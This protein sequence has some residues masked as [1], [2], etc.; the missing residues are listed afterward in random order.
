[1]SLSK[2]LAA[3][4]TT[5]LLATIGLQSTASAGPA[6]TCKGAITGGTYES[7]VVPEG[8]KCTLT[9]VTVA[10]QVQARKDSKLYVRTSNIKLVHGLKAEIVHVFNSTIG[11]HIHV[12]QGNINDKGPDIQI[13]DTKVGGNI[14]LHDNV[15]TIE[16]QRNV[17]SGQIQIQH[18]QS[19]L[20]ITHNQVS[21]NLQVMK[22]TSAESKKV[23]FNSVD[24]QIHCLDNAAPF[25]GGP[26]A[27]ASKV[28]GACFVG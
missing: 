3:V 23:Q 8:Q 26:N 21:K 2:R 16:V 28:Q 4:G 22:T 27:K 24:G 5:L 25:T 9:N 19:H 1:M 18:N 17:V 14:H 6:T 7:I 11:Q 15:G 10:G 20:L 12:Q 13:E